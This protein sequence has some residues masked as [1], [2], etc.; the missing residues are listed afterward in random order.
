[1]TS[2]PSPS[3]KVKVRSVVH[4]RKTFT[5]AIN[6]G[7]AENSCSRFEGKLPLAVNWNY[8]LSS[9]NLCSHS[10]LS[11]CGNENGNGE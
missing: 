8:K 4:R 9:L 2:Y 10:S 3:C 1:M 5:D 6:S 11:L 7:V